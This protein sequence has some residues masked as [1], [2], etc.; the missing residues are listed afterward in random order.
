[1]RSG[2]LLEF[3][4]VMLGFFLCSLRLGLTWFEARASLQMFSFSAFMLCLEN[5]GIGQWQ[6]LV[7]KLEV[8]SALARSSGVT[9]RVEKSCGGLCGQLK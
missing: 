7:G 2:V 6:E 8:T 4:G 3:L 9:E 1:M 5:L